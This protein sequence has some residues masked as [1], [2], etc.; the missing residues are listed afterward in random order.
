MLMP[1]NKIVD[2][3]KK[4]FTQIIFKQI[5]RE[6]NWAADAMA[7]IA[8]LIDMPQNETFY[9]FLVD[10][11][12]VPSYEITPTEIICFIGLD[13]PQSE[14]ILTYLCNNTLPPDL[15]NNQCHIFIHKYS[16]YI[17]LFDTLYLWILD[18]TLLRCLESDQAQILICEVHKGI[19]GA[20][21]SGPNLANKLMR[22]RYYWITM[23]KDSSIC[24][25][26]IVSSTY[27][28]TLFTH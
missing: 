1:Y 6:N 16:W 19:C 23:E 2:Y 3:F 25:T 5:S 8:S 9:Y 12:L 13:S 4:Y 22:I 18:G 14:A 24:Y 21:S 28:E 15:S 7:T 11:I 27:I 10:N 17:V 20:H 26:I